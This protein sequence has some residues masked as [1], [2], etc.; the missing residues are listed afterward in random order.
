MYAI[1]N[2]IRSY[3]VTTALLIS[4]LSEQVGNCYPVRK[5]SVVKTKEELVDVLVAI[6]VVTTTG[7]LAVFQNYGNFLGGKNKPSVPD[8]HSKVY[9]FIK[10]MKLKSGYEGRMCDYIG[11]LYSRSLMNK[12]TGTVKEFITFLKDCREKLISMFDKDEFNK[13]VSSDHSYNYYKS[14]IGDIFKSVGSNG[15]SKNGR[16]HFISHIVVSHMDEIFINTSVEEIDV[17]LGYNGAHGP[18]LVDCGEEA[19]NKH[20]RWNIFATFVLDI[21][22]SA[23]TEELDVWGLERVNNLVVVKI[24][25]RPIGLIDVE[26]ISCKL[27]ATDERSNGSR[28]ISMTPNLYQVYEWPQRIEFGSLTTTLA[29]IATNAVR[30]FS[31]NKLFKSMDIN[32]RFKFRE[33]SIK[34][35]NYVSLGG[36][37]D[38]DNCTTAAEKYNKEG[39][40]C[41]K[42]SRQGKKRKQITVDETVRHT[43]SR[44]THNAVSYYGN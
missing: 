32:E 31:T 16:P 39:K 7:R 44:L 38:I 9:D 11:V 2:P 6:I 24:N 22:E 36:K 5:R 37:D 1:P 25:H 30:A 8:T 40:L 43:S 33:E 23:C 17:V 13:W 15:T 10:F 28:L 26:C 3:N 20:D 19:K 18:Y 27:V 4:T 42:T 14:K 34:W 35:T 29:G 41:V 21:I 12:C